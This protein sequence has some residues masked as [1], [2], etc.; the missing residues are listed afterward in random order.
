MFYNRYEKG[1]KVLHDND[2]SKACKQSLKMQQTKYKGTLISLV[3]PPSLVA[4]APPIPPS[5]DQCLLWW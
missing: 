1:S 2:T 5:K 4:E 3:A